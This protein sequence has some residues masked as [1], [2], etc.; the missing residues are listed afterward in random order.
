VLRY[1]FG[2][3][4]IPVPEDREGIYVVRLDEDGMEPRKIARASLEPE[5]TIDGAALLDILLGISP[6]LSFL[7]N[8][9]FA[10]S[11]DWRMVVFAARGTGRDGSE[12]P[13]IR[14]LHVDASEAEPTL[15]T[16]LPSTPLVDDDPF[17]RSI[18]CYPPTACP[19]F[20]GERRVAFF[21][22]VNADDRPEHAA[23]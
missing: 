1:F 6:D 3:T 16:D 8:P 10:F 23:G 7:M 13:Q 20:V 22:S 17:C 15:L 4:E 5:P 18:G 21:T 9:F 11:P 12:T 14:L 19:S 2:G